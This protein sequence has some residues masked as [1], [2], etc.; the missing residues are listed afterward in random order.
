MGLT[1]AYPNHCSACG[2]RVENCNCAGEG[3]EAQARI[4]AEQK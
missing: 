2:L 4:E 1:Q 3:K